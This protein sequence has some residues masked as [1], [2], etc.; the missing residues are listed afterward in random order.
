VA[1]GHQI[2]DKITKQMHR[3][4]G[5]FEIESVQRAEQRLGESSATDGCDE[6]RSF[7]QHS[8][9]CSERDKDQLLP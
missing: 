7:D 4:R 3:T 5:Y 1:S 9:E 6:P 8:G 2:G